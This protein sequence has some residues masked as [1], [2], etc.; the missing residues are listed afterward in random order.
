MISKLWDFEALTQSIIKMSLI[1]LKILIEF[2]WDGLNFG[3][4]DTSCVPTE[5][6]KIAHIAG[7]LNKIDIRSKVPILFFNYRYIIAVCLGMLLWHLFE[8]AELHE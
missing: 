8:T 5:T 7:A 2:S 3:P 4:L 6:E 1:S